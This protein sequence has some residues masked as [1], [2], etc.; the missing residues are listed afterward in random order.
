M[1]L[2]VVVSL[3]IMSSQYPPPEADG[4][5]KYLC[6]IVSNVQTQDRCLEL[7]NGISYNY[8]IATYYE[9][10]LVRPFACSGVA[11]F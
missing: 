6:A 11:M 9:R 10:V 5:K 2:E 1:W 4:L 7:L 3:E 8:E